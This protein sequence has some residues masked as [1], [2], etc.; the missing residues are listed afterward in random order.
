MTTIEITEPTTLLRDWLRGKSLSVDQDVYAGGRPS[1]EPLPA[2]IVFP[3][4]IG[5][6]DYQVDGLYQ[7]DCLAG[8]PIDAANLAAELVSLLVSQTQPFTFTDTTTKVHGF[9][10]IDQIPDLDP[11]PDLSRTI[12]TAQ[13]TTTTTP[14]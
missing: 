3:I 7:F 5:V 2:I 13:A 10:N 9:Y 6:V 4:S 1:S 12:V 14:S 11:D 8:K